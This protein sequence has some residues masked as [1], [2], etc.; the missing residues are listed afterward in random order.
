MICACYPAIDWT[1]P[2]RR[3]QMRATP[4]LNDNHVMETTHFPVECRHCGNKGRMDVLAEKSLVEAFEDEAN[5][6]YPEH[7][8]EGSIYQILRCCVCRDI[9]FYQVSVHTG[10]D[11]EYIERGYDRTLLPL[12]WRVTGRPAF[13]CSVGMGCGA[14]SAQN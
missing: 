12:R 13:Q 14:S 11:P 6:M 4:K 10:T 5:G 9:T 1:A 2:T 8:E 3:R 7:W